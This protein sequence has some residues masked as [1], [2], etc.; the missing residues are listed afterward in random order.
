MITFSINKAEIL[1]NI[2]EESELKNHL[3]SWQSSCNCEYSYYF[4][5]IFFPYLI[6]STY[7]ICEGKDYFR[8]TLR[9]FSCF[10]FWEFFHKIFSIYSYVKGQSWLWPHPTSG[11][12]YFYTYWECFQITFSFPGKNDFEKIFKE[13]S[14]LFLCKYST[15]IMAPPFPR[16]SRIKQT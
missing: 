6:I 5:N 15:S 4:R 1:I 9:T 8:L 13:F 16:G 14:N 2:Y 12:H 3:H 10:S 11:D 7:I